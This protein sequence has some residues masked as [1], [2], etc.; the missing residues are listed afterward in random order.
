[1]AP[2]PS[3]AASP[4]PSIVKAVLFD[5]GG[6]LTRLNPPADLFEPDTVAHLMPAVHRLDTGE[7][8]PD[9]FIAHVAG[10]THK[11]A[12]EIAAVFDGWIGEPYADLDGLIDDLHQA[13]VTTACLSNTNA[14]H[15]AVLVGDTHARPP[16]PPLLPLRRLHHRF[17]SFEMRLRKPGR[18]IYTRAAALLDRPPSEL[19]FF[20][21]TE[22]NVD[23]ARDAGWHAERIDPD[24][25]TVPQMRRHLA[26]RGVLSG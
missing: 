25:E 12:D 23:A 16:I 26:E 11:P 1:M 17:A 7:V 14:R 19:M 8:A 2:P 9:D 4:S 5:I 24:G 3:Q 22:E 20:D 6:V 15:W 21:D 13:G 18:D 10:V